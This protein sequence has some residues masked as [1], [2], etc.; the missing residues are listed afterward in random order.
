MGMQELVLILIVI[1]IMGIVLGS[2]LMGDKMTKTATGRTFARVLIFLS[3]AGGPLGM[4]I[5]HGLFCYKGTCEYCGKQ[6]PIKNTPCDLSPTG[7][8]KM[9]I[10]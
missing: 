1:V 10:E 6:Y 4:A 9:K 2:R 7:M 5:T 3:C 8:H